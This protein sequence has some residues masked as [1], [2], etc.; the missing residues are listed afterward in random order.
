MGLTEVQVRCGGV[1]VCL[2]HFTWKHPALVCICA[3]S[4]ALWAVAVINIFLLTSVVPD[5][6]AKTCGNYAH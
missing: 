6:V 4:A 3:L 5:C 2:V 1:V